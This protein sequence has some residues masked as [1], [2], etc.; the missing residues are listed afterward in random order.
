MDAFSEYESANNLQNQSK[1]LW[2]R[3]PSILFYDLKCIVSQLD[4]MTLPFH[5][6]YEIRIENVY[7]Y[8]DHNLNHNEYQ[9][10]IKKFVFSDDI[11]KSYE[12]NILSG[13]FL[14]LTITGFDNG[15]GNIIAYIFY[16]K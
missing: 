13:E 14:L 5:E 15:S 7:T 12:N 4:L 10:Q 6:K 16:E 9:E 2:A 11:L 1:C 8:D 3:L